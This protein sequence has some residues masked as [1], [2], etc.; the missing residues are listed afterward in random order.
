MF[1]Q[2]SV[3]FPYIELY[4]GRESRRLLLPENDYIGFY[5][6]PDGNLTTVPSQKTFFN[7][8]A[9]PGSNSVTID[10]STPG[11]PKLIQ[12]VTIA[13]FGGSEKIIYELVQLDEGANLGTTGLIIEM[14]PLTQTP[15]QAS[16]LAHGAKTLWLGRLPSIFLME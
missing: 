1:F 14:M 13:G 8:P 4:N 16:L 6:R 9:W 7:A 11:N 12:T 15:F 5:I 10:T 2:F 3:E